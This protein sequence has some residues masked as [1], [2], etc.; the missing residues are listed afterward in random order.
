MACMGGRGQCVMAATSSRA[1]LALAK[2]D[3]VCAEEP[4]VIEKLGC[5][6][7]CKLGLERGGTLL[8]LRS[9]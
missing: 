9:M 3:N 1:D 8:C 5:K 4:P 2:D 6:V 7:T